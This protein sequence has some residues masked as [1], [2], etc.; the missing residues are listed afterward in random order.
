MV[1]ERGPSQDDTGPVSG[2][3][4]F[5]HSYQGNKWRLQIT[6][7]FGRPVVHFRKWY[8]VG[9]TFRPSKKEGCTIPVERL[10]ELVEAIQGWLLEN[11]TSEPG[12]GS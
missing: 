12:S 5:E 3:V 1:N 2:V 8:P 7:Y 11:G 4:L 6:P 9:D 10:P